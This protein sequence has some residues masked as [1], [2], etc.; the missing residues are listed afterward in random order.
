MI[1]CHG[2]PVRIDQRLFDPC[3]RWLSIGGGVFLPLSHAQKRMPKARKR[4]RMPRLLSEG[5]G[6]HQPKMVS[7]HLY[8]RI[9]VENERTPF[10]LR[11]AEISCRRLQGL[12]PKTELPSSQR[13]SAERRFAR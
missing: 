10:L 9:E 11:L 3:R 4:G 8:L 2:A 13:P 5:S 6:R 12:L 7:V 1:H